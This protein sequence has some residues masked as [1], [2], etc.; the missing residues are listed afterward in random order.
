MEEF[1][2]LSSNSNKSMY[3]MCAR[4]ANVLIMYCVYLVPIIYECDLWMNI[5]SVLS[6]LGTNYLVYLVYLVPIIY[7]SGLWTNMLTVSD[8]AS[9]CVVYI[10]KTNRIISNVFLMCC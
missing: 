8:Q 10:R 7:E 5:L 3:L 6:V 2:V 1:N 4:V 9:I